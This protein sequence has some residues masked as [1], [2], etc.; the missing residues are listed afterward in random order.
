VLILLHSTSLF[1]YS[2]VK[3]FDFWSQI[4]LLMHLIKKQSFICSCPRFYHHLSIKP[5]LVF[6]KQIKN[7]LRSKF[8]LGC[9]VV[10][11]IVTFYVTFY[12][13]FSFLRHPYLKNDRKIVVISFE[14]PSAGVGPPL[15][16][17]PR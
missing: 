8:W 17:I 16:F 12:V 9:L 11:L 3:Y 13:T 10:R 6:K 5:K 15:F 7:L 4:D 14:Y 2:H 1:S